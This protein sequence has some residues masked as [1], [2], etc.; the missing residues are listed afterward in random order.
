M[1][2]ALLYGRTGAL[3]MAQ[4]GRM[5]AGHRPDSLVICAFTFIAAGLLVKGAML[6][7]HFWL[8]DAH[9]VA[10]SPVC[11]LFS[12]VMVPLGLYGLVRVYWTMFAGIPGF[13]PAVHSLILGVGL[14]T[15]IVGSVMCLLQRHLKR[16]LAFS[17]I[18]H[19]GLLASGFALLTPS[20]LAGMG[21]YL[22]GH[23]LV[24]G[25]LFMCSGIVLY[26]A[27]SV[28]ELEL[29]H[30]PVRSPF[31]MCVYC[32]AAVGLAGMPPFCTAT[33]K[34]L[35]EE[36]AHG[37]E[38]KLIVIVMTLTSAITAAAVLRARG[39]IFLGWGKIVGE[40]GGGPTERRTEPEAQFLLGLPPVMLAPAAVLVALTLLL[41]L[42]PPF[43]SHAV[44]ASA[45]AENRAAYPAM[46]LN[47]R[48]ADVMTPPTPHTLW[49]S[50]YLS[51]GGAIL[52][53][54]YA[55]FGI[56]LPQ[57]IAK[58][59]DPAVKFV[60]KIHSGRIGDYITWLVVGV[61]VYGLV[62]TAVVKQAVVK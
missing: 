11:V 34:S 19:M 52:I 49:T 42:I 54:L 35:I 62:L 38:A 56:E 40:E 10:P 30:R 15:A 55:L 37:A 31:T 48:V 26:E 23:G 16:L 27:E 5:L 57:F 46:V 32:V 2:I 47:G 17:T 6:P 44:A 7:F 60:N 39:R 33:G 21:I 43:A 53:A 59:V 8:S 25:S 45:G 41:G 29:A 3:N 61:A 22:I 12:G 36:A 28:D 51:G 14:S 1:G 4:I 13:A 9:A 58:I 24:K 50:G 18:S 20:A